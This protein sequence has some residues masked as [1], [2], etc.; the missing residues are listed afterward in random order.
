MRT[1]R[2]LYVFVVLAGGV[3]CSLGMGDGYTG[4]TVSDGGVVRRPQQKCPEGRTVCNGQ[5]T[6][7]QSDPSNCGGC[8]HACNEGDTCVDNACV[9]R[10]VGAVACSGK[11][12]DTSTSPVHCGGCNQPCT[13]SAPLCSGGACSASC[14][15]ATTCKPDAGTPYCASTLGD[16]HNCGGCGI[17]CSESQTCISGK[18]TLGCASGAAVGDIYSGDMIG[19][20]GKVAWTD[21][22]KLCPPGT[23]VCTADEWAQRRGTKAPTYSYWTSQDLGW[24]GTGPDE[25]CSVDVV[26]GDFVSCEGVPM[27]VCPGATDPLGNKCNWTNCGLRTNTPNQFFGGCEGNLTAGTLCCK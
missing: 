27:R 20:T 1:P 5:C 7:T 11:C 23:R 17:E 16:R 9:V 25:P 10:C 2:S 3:A 24:N 21:R 8:G 18:C 12:V 15:S 4:G 14:G 22:T 26:G 19:C 6:D 13:G